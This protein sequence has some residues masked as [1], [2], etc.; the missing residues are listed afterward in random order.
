MAAAFVTPAGASFRDA[1][2]IDERIMHCPEKQRVP[3]QASLLL[4]RSSGLGWNLGTSTPFRIARAG[5]ASIVKFRR[6]LRRLEDFR[7]MTVENLRVVRVTHQPK[8][9]IAA[10]GVARILCARDRRDEVLVEVF[11]QINHV[12]CE[13]DRTGLR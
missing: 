6:L 8:A 1:R 4:P 5:S 9:L 3:W 11:L 10:I 2:S 12:T 13:D 7:I